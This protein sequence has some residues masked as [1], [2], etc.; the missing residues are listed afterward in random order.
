MS[1]VASNSLNLALLGGGVAVALAATW[2]LGK[3]DTLKMPSNPFGVKCSPYGEVF[4]MAM[5]GPI[6]TYWHGGEDCHDEN[7][8]NPEHHHHDGGAE[9]HE[10]EKEVVPTTFGARLDHFLAELDEAVETRTNRKE[11]SPAQKFYLRREVE[12]KLRF[13]YDLDP[14]HYGNYNSYFFF[15]TE[16]SVGTRPELTQGAIKL[17]ENTIRYCLSKN[18]DPRP[19]LT[20][21]AA[22]YNEL[23]VMFNTPERYATEDMRKILSLMDIS[24]AR[25]AEIRAAWEESGLWT[26]LSDER[27]QEI[28]ERVHYATKSRE[29]AEVTILRLEGK[30][31]PQ[32]VN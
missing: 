21:A 8:T 22:C 31:Q 29:A 19:P 12:D 23:M 5:Q 25:H 14:S 15:L 1:S 4:A 11:P 10:E 27:R 24:I 17:T 7:C 3:D 28:Q 32:A 6:D 18:D 30:S 16:P 13:A 2:P 9:H 26:E 20:A